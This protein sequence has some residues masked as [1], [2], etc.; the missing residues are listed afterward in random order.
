MRIVDVNRALRYAWLTAI[1]IAGL[2][3]ILGSAPSG[4]PFVVTGAPFPQPTACSDCELRVEVD[5]LGTGTVSSA[6]AGIAGCRGPC[7]ALFRAGTEVALTATPDAAHT[8]GRWTGAC[9]GTSPTTRVLVDVSKSCTVTFGPG[10]QVASANAK[11]SAVSHLA[12]VSALSPAGRLLVGYLQNLGAQTRVGVLRESPD[13]LFANLPDVNDQVNQTWSAHELDLALDAA[14]QPVLAIL[15]DLHDIAVA[16]WNDDT[17]LWNLVGR[18]INLSGGA[19]RSPQI[20]VA[21]RVPGQQTL[22]VAWVE[23][24]QIVVRRYAVATRSWSTAAFI[25]GINRVRSVR[26]MLDANG[27]QVIAYWS[28]T[29][30]VIRETAAGGWSALGGA[31]NIQPTDGTGAA[32]FGVHVD[33]SGAVTVAWVE[34]VSTLSGVGPWAIHA[35]RFDGSNWVSAFTNRPTGLVYDSAS[36]TR[37]FPN[38]LVVARTPAEFAFATAWDSVATGRSDVR[39]VGVA[40]T[41]EA[42]ELAVPIGPDRFL[43]AANVSLAMQDAGRAIVAASYNEPTV[44]PPYALQIRRFFP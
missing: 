19:G 27:A 17:R 37:T 16:H 12:T 20:A 29:L 22:I 14:D 40:P 42:Q 11:S 4:G 38:S 1:G 15:V 23:A 33:A 9:T 10:W 41:G 5:A 28:D 7:A 26:M 44:M 31:I 32:R 2:A 36:N 30:N 8:F 3:S 43:R 39:A 24:E 13:R 35:R 18:R 25:P 34:G 6:P 21:G